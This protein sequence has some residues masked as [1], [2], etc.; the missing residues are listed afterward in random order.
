YARGQNFVLAVSQPAS[1]AAFAREAQPDEYAII[2]PE[3]QTEVEI[4]TA[5]GAQAVK[6]NSLAFVPPGRSSLK[7]LKP[8]L[9]VRMFTTQAAHLAA[10][11]PNAAAYRAPKPQVAPAAPWPT[12]KDGLKLRVYSLDVPP[13]KGRFGRIWRCT[14]LMVNFIDPFQGPRDPTKLSPHHH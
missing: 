13:E 12:P 6:G 7:V 11:C 1:D 4:T 8:G 10:K 3:A 9:I 5:H 2:L 14:T